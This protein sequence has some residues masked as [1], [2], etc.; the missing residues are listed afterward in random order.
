MAVRGAL[1]A[2]GDTGDRASARWLRTD[3]RGG[4]ISERPTPRDRTLAVEGIDA[5]IAEA[6]KIVTMLMRGE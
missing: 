3:P 5:A 2:A 6:G 1:A 4:L